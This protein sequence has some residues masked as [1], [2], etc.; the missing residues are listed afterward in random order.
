MDDAPLGWKALLASCC[1]GAKLPDVSMAMLLKLLSVPL[2]DVHA[3]ASE[4]CSRGNSPS[5]AG[6]VFSALGTSR[7]LIGRRTLD[8]FFAS[9]AAF[10]T[11]SALSR[12]S[13]HG[14]I[15][16]GPGGFLLVP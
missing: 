7:F 6:V 16:S 5:L 15:F 11:S 12:A 2:A 10:D 1:N 13:V 8:F 4:N 3:Q 9:A 14:L